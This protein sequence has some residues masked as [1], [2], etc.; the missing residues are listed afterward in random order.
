MMRRISVFAVIA[1]VGAPWLV[2][3]V[4]GTARALTIAASGHRAPQSRVLLTPLAGPSRVATLEGVGCSEAICSRVAVRTRPADREDRAQ[5]LVRFDT[6]AAIKLNKAGR[7][8]ID[9]VAAH[10]DKWS[11][12]LRIGSSICWMT[13]TGPTDWTYDSSSPSSSS[14]EACRP[15]G[16]CWRRDDGL[17]SQHGVRRY[18]PQLPDDC[19]NASGAGCVSNTLGRSGLAGHLVGRRFDGSSPRSGYRARDEE[20]PDGG[21]VSSSPGADARQRVAQ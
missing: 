19:P 20:S 16:S 6:I 14:D 4:A 5:T 12:R 18:R 8:T 11:F 17:R 9:F 3:E 21:G 7:A 13:L 10:R 1:L 15:D 2:G